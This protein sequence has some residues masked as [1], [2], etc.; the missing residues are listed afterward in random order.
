MKKEVNPNVFNEI[1]SVLTK[2]GHLFPQ[3]GSRYFGYDHELSDYDFMTTHNEMKSGL[4]TTFTS[5]KN[6]SGGAEY[7]SDQSLQGTLYEIIDTDGRKIQI[8]AFDTEADCLTQIRR[9]REL[10]GFLL[11]NADILPYIA[12]QK[13]KYHSEESNG[14]IFFNEML[15]FIKFEHMDRW[16]FT[17]WS[18]SYRSIQEAKGRKWVANMMLPIFSMVMS[19]ACTP[20][21]LPPKVRVLTI[22]ADD[23]F[24]LDEQLIINDQPSTVV[25]D[26]VS[27][28]WVKNHHLLVKVFQNG[29][30][31]ETYLCDVENNL[32][33]KLAPVQPTEL[34]V[35]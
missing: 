4:V 9:N 21:L 26:G 27:Y 23:C 2:N 32:K 30:L 19:S 8:L 14:S 11:N 17:E 3:I 28:Q 29:Q 13:R 16:Q 25:G 15:E 34:I 31:S 5:I 1:L 7:S 6:L 35:S 10:K 12:Q 33:Y 20:T 18:D 24:G 22:K